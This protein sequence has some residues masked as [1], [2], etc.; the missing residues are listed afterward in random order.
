M[1]KT[2]A[3]EKI[4]LVTASKMFK[5]LFK[6]CADSDL[7]YTANVVIVEKGDNGR[8]GQCAATH[9]EGSD[10]M[11]ALITSLQQLADHPLNGRLWAPAMRSVSS[12]AGGGLGDFLGM[13]MGIG[14]SERA[15]AKKPKREPKVKRDGNVLEFPGKEKE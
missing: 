11:P 13:M 1:T 3:K 12:Q 10:L 14:P 7:Q 2:K 4:D 15:P 5:A 9:G 8:C 6:L